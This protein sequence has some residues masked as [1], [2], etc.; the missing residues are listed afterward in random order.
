MLP[1]RQ[2][3]SDLRR[4]AYRPLHSTDPTMVWPAQPGPEAIQKLAMLQQ[5]ELS[6]WWSPEEL[7]SQ[8][9]RQAAAL[10]D[11]AHRQLPFYRDQL[12]EAGFVRGQALTP[13][14]WGRIP[15]LSRAGLQTAGAE[16]YAPE[17]PP[18]HGKVYE[19][20]T[21]GSTGRP[22]KART[23]DIV[24]FVWDVMTLREHLWHRRDFSS[25]LA[26]IRS[27]RNG[28][29]DFPEGAQSTCWNRSIAELFGEGPAVA[30][31][32][33][34]RTEEQA[35]WL[36]RHQPNYLLIY[37]SALREL[38]V[39]C[40]DRG[41]RFPNLRQVRTLSELLSPDIR[42]L[43]CEVWGVEIADLYST[44]ET[45]YL[46]IQCPEEGA[47][48]VQSEAAILEVLDDDGAPCAAGQVGNVIVTPLHNFAMP[49]LRYAVG[50]LAEVGEACPCGRGLP[51]LKR[52]LGRAR[53][54]LVYPGG[55][56]TWALLG[57]SQFTKIP[58]VR[59]FQI[60]QHAVDDLE[61]K[62]VS[63]RALT[64]EEEAQLRRWMQDRCGHDFPIRF[65]YHDHIPR[66]ASGKYQDFLC[67]IPDAA[68][69]ASQSQ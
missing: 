25:K 26:A 23:S 5:L 69:G 65:T 7:L 38:L 35:E 9:L 49:M 27:Y 56:K 66:S 4:P 30:L 42:Q 45:G 21:S 63:D 12:S 39:Y 11:H 34:A 31:H 46:A 37:P 8:Q 41:L 53:D 48:H 61:I 64:P 50:D 16:L 33:G 51:V 19:L 20:S 32:I 6:Q 52:I 15:T 2:Q 1:P 24:Q 62:L 3:H 40:R 14:I 57:S 44:Q 68:A 58:A 43:C 10:L 36:Q 22:V 28:W 29:A 55:R 59:Q 13:E 67:N 60:V 47:Y 17:L 18:G 54:M